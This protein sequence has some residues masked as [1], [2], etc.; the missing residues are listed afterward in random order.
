MKRNFTCSPDMVG[1]ITVSA[2]SSLTAS[3][4]EY[5]PII[6]GVATFTTGTAY[7]REIYYDNTGINYG[8]DTSP[9]AL[10]AQCDNKA[11]VQIKGIFYPIDLKY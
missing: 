7:P 4:N 6:A 8:D 11:T 1:T 3:K 10:P 9:V 5:H 2:T